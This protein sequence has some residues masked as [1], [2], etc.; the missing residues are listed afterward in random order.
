MNTILSNELISNIE[1]MAQ[2]FKDKDWDTLI[3]KTHVVIELCRVYR[4]ARQARQRGLPAWYDHDMEMLKNL[5]EQLP[6]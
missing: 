3:V 1:R 2:G 4:L 6:E 5:L